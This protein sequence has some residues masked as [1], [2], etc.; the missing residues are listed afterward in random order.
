MS[1]MFAR[2]TKHGDRLVVPG[3]R[4]VVSAL[5]RRPGFR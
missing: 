4:E 3:P 5:M 2:K 1:R